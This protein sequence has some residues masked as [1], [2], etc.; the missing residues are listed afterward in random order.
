[1][2][3]RKWLMIVLLDACRRLLTPGIKATV[4]SKITGLVIV[5]EVMALQLQLWLVVVNKL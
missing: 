3:Q 5:P 1:M 2:P 4:N